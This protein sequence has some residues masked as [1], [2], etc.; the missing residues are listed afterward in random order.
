MPD[1]DAVPL[2]HPVG[3]IVMWSGLLS[4]IPLGWLLAD[5]TN[6]TPNLTAFFV[7]G[8]PPTNEPGAIS[9]EDFNQLASSEMPVHDH[10]TSA[11]H[12]HDQELSTV[13]DTGGSTGLAGNA[14]AGTLSYST[15]SPSISFGS[16]GSSQTHENKPPFF[17][18]AFIQRVS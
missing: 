2:P 5:G 14:N 10:T 18:L 1:L 11:G 12:K 6:G 7:R 8:A 3:T 4:V 16:A 15:E 9:G 17:E 13:Q